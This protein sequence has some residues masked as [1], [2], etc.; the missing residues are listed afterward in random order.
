MKRPT[1]D[2]PTEPAPSNRL[3]LNEVASLQ[4]YLLNASPEDRQRVLTDLEFL[5][6]L[7]VGSTIRM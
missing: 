6:N 3:E 7:L 5:R 2:R 1:K 4:G